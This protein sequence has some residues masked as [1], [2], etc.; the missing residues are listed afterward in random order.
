MKKE[1]VLDS[2]VSEFSFHMVRYAMCLEQKLQFGLYTCTGWSR[3]DLEIFEIYVG[4]PV[5]MNSKS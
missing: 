2:Y 4:K 5:S 3:S 1:W